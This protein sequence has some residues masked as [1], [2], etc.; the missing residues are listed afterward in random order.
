METT[1][2]REYTKLLQ[3]TRGLVKRDTLSIAG[4]QIYFDW[5]GQ[6]VKWNCDTRSECGKIAV[7]STL[8]SNIFTYLCAL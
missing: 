3:E 1:L 2:D 4:I 5:V 7:S 6:R 8:I